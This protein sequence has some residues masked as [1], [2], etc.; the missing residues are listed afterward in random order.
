[1]A[2]MYQVLTNFVPSQ[3]LS[4]KGSS[5]FKYILHM[6]VHFV[7]QNKQKEG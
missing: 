4:S 5:Y 1:M 7:L 2:I 3:P 6:C